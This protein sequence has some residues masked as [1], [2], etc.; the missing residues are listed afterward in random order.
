MRFWSKPDIKEL[1]KMWNDFVPVEE[2]AEHFD[3][4]VK[5]I[6]GKVDW[7]KKKGESFINRNITPHGRERWI[8]HMGYVYVRIDK[9]PPE[10]RRFAS[11]LDSRNNYVFEHRYIASK[12]LGRPLKRF[13]EEVVHHL[14]GIRTDNRPENLGITSNSSHVR[15]T[16]IS[17]LQERIRELEHSSHSISGETHIGKVLPIREWTERG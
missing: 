4:T 8:N 1:R 9:I 17:L 5:A 10:D 3:R 16:L 7:E 15:Q 2:I 13:P 12:K 11:K 6:Y 14:N